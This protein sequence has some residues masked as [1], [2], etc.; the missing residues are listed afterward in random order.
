MSID[1]LY[2]L[3]T[4]GGNWHVDYCYCCARAGT[5]TLLNIHTC[6]PV[7]S[8]ENHPL[9]PKHLFLVYDQIIIINV[10]LLRWLSQALEGSTYDNAAGWAR[11]VRLPLTW[12]AILDSAATAPYAAFFSRRK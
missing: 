7:L 11:A 2:H 6:R 4:L 1:L 10:V 9:R 8:D 3:C 5:P 12:H